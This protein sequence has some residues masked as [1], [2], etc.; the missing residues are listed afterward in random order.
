MN[1]DDLEC[2]VRIVESGSFS[3]AAMQLGCDHSTLSRTIARL[4]ADSC[5][6]LLHRSGRG[7]SPTEAGKALYKL[8]LDVV[9]RIED[10]RNA[11][12]IFQDRGPR[13]LVLAA[14]PT[15]AHLAMVPLSQRFREQFPETKLKIIEGLGARVQSLLASGEVDIALFYLPRRASEISV[16]VLLNER[17]SLVSPASHTYCGGTFPVAGLADVPL[18]LPSTHYGLRTLAED[19]AQ[20][21]GVSLTIVAECDGSNG[22]IKRLVQAGL[23]STILPLAAVA[24]EV[25]QGKLRAARLVKPDV[26]RQI[27]IAASNNRAPLV[28]QWAMMRI[29]QDEIAKIVQEGRWPDATLV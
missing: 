17:I 15:I 21:V 14:Q 12:R 22:L 11:V 29:V 5:V 23:G 25:A 27:G 19:L 9:C 4:E 20:E 18:I 7:V 10:A 2:F 28:S 1:S 26:V 16:D 8:S 6:R 13:S 3:K 24:D